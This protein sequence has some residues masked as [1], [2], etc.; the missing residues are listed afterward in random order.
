MKRL[1]ACVIAPLLLLALGCGQTEASESA[2]AS[3]VE[4]EESGSLA[5][6]IREA[7]RAADA[8]VWV[9]YEVAVNDPKCYLCCFDS[10]DDAKAKGWRGG[11]CSLDRSSSFFSSHGDDAPDRSVVERTHVSV[12]LRAER[13]AIGEVRIF[14]PDCRVDTGDAVVTR[15]G[16]VDPEESVRFLARLVDE[17]AANRSSLRRVRNDEA[18]Q[19]VAAIAMHKAAATIPALV[20]IV[21]SERDEELRAHAAFWLGMKGGDE[22]RRVLS[23]IVDRTP[24]SELREQA[25]AGIAQDESDEAVELLLRL[26]RDHRIAEVREHALFWLA[27]KAGEKVVGQLEAATDDPDEDVREMAVFSISRLPAE[28]SIPRLIELA[29]SH[30]SPGVREQALFW[31]GQSGDERALDFIEE[32]LTR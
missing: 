18:E 10:F 3:G 17:I 27:E 11:T 14:S 12:F 13:G 7:A 9:A 29:R 15:L 21:E 32:I 19:V 30:E 25:I 26:A 24:S 28:Q 2:G 8:T 23:R 1:T 6:R 16:I 4:L 5:P 20:S 31:L 22:G